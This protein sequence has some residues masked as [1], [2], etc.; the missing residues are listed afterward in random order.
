MI[1]VIRT[2]WPVNSFRGWF[3]YRVANKFSDTL[4]E[5]F[6]V[7]CLISNFFCENTRWILVS[8]PH[9]WKILF[10]STK[11]SLSYSLKRGLRSIS[12]NTFVSPFDTR[13][14]K[15]NSNA[16]CYSNQKY[17]GLNKSIR[18]DNLFYFTKIMMI[19]RRNSIFGRKNS[20]GSVTKGLTNVIL[21][22]DLRS[23]LRL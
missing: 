23:R 10:K 17:L 14:W 18:M 19:C 4:N 22:I 1:I 21:D 9:Y 16:V 5:L 13:L 12:K 3:Y 20:Q 6:V 11:H 8:S 7:N 15:R 2:F